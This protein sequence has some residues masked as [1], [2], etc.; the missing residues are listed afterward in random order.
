MK[1]QQQRQKQKQNRTKQK[2]KKKIG[3]GF[4]KHKNVN[5]HFVI[6][7]VSQFLIQSML[8]LQKNRGHLNR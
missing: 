3:A 6:G 5:C 8:I 4:F 2:L 7:M 1:K